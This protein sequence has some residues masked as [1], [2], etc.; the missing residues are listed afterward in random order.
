MKTLQIEQTEVTPLVILDAKNN[1]FELS[2]KSLPENV[3]KFY[4][5]IFDWFDAYSK[6]PNSETKFVIKLKYFNTMSGK[7]MIE[8]LFKLKE[9]S[10]KGSNISIIWYYDYND[11][12]YIGKEYSEI[13]GIPFKFKKY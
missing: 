3:L 5:P 7:I 11:M 2:G 8:L 6:S 12:L 10:K 13:V 9:I 4:K 1:V